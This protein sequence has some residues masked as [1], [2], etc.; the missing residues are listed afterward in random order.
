MFACHAIKLGLEVIPLI[1][2]KKLINQ[3]REDTIVNELCVGLSIAILKLHYVIQYHPPTLRYN[4][5][6]VTA[7]TM[8]EVFLSNIS[9]RKIF[10]QQT[11]NYLSAEEFYN[12]AKL[13]DFMKYLEELKITFRPYRR[14]MTLKWKCIHLKEPNNINHNPDLKSIREIVEL[15]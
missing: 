6:M 4:V 15:E 13:T 12:D 2:D 11:L 14:F 7:F 3:N 5:H 10:H 9:T 8:P 1:S